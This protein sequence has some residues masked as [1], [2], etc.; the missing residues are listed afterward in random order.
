[1]DWLCPNEGYWALESMDPKNVR[2][3][4]LVLKVKENTNHLA[5]GWIAQG[6]SVIEQWASVYSEV[7]SKDRE[8][9]KTCW[10]LERKDCSQARG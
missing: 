7:E 10:Y 1:M 3:S 2:V 4:F 8:L 6:S 9:D 5:S